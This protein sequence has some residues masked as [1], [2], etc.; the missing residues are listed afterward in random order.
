M[1]TREERKM[2]PNQHIAINNFYAEYPSDLDYVTCLE[3][4]INLDKN[5]LFKKHP[6]YQEES[7]F[8]ISLFIERLYD[9]LNEGD[10]D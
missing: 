9:L 5:H 8:L 10:V 6:Y 1:Q 7:C 4:S 3:H 2:T